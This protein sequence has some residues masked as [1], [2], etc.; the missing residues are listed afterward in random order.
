MNNTWRAWTN[1]RVGCV[2]WNAG[3]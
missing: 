1:I 2:I 3:C